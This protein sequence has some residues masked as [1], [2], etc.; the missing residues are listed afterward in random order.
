MS[1]IAWSVRALREGGCG[2]LVVAVPADLVTETRTTLTD[3]TDLSVVAGGPRRQ[4]SVF[5]ALREIDA[6]TVLVHDAA[7]PLVAPEVVRDLVQSLED[8]DGA[9]VAVPVDETIKR[10]VGGEISETVDRTDLWQA[11]T[12]Q[13]FRTSILRDAHER[14]RKDGFLAT[15]DASLLER[16]G[17]RVRVVRGSRTN[18]KVTY[19]EDF[20][21]AEALAEIEF[22]P[23]TES[24]S[25][26]S[27]T[28]AGSPADT[29][30]P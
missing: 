13:G 19:P 16:Y 10:V 6:D 26:A 21:L 22:A 7:R 11:Q 2:T 17:G 15:D 25:A 8:W 14:A 29:S 3:V 28:G 30:T 23:G 24:S 27:T 18:I 4:D 12:P 5:E 9:V 20:A 1:L